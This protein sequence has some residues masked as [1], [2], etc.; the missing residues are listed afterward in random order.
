MKMHAFSYI[1]QNRKEGFSSLTT[2]EKIYIFL[3]NENPIVK[4]ITT[5][6]LNKDKPEY[7]NVGYTDNKSAYGYIY[8]GERWIKKEIQPIMNDLLDSKEQDL[9][10]IHDQIRGYLSEDLNNSIKNKL[11]EIQCTIQPKLES[12]VKSKK[13]LVRNIKTKFYNDR[14]LVLESMKR[15]EQKINNAK[16]EDNVDDLLMKGLKEV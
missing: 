3:L 6:N 5:T 4:I 10:K 1:F 11:N 14:S 2:Q 16:K 12:H 7:H 8:D 13:D 15:S 9:A